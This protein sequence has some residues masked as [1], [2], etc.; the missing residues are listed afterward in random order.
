VAGLEGAEAELEVLR[1]AEV[2]ALDLLE[3]GPA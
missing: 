2:R 3:Q 1:R